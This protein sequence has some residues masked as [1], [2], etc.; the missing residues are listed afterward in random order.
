MKKDVIQALSGIFPKTV[1]S[2]ETLNHP[3]IIKHVSGIDVY[4]DTAKAFE[5]AWAKLG[6]DIHSEMPKEN[7][8]RPKVPGGTWEEDGKIYSDYGVYPT[9]MPIE[10]ES[11]TGEDVIQ[12]V[13]NYDT[14]EDDFDL[15]DVKKSLCLRNKRFNEAFGDSA[16]MYHVF[17]TT[18]FM[19]PVVKFGW[20][21]FMTAA[22][23]DPDRFDKELWEPW[24][25]ISRKYFQV[26]AAIDE[27]V[28]FC[29]DD[30]VMTTGPVFSP[31]FYDK[32]IF[33]KYEWIMEPVFEAGKKLV[34][35]CDGNMD[36]FLE[37]L[38][39]FPIAAI[40]FENPA[41]PFERVLDT[42]GEAGRGFIGGIS[43]KLLTDGS[44]EDVCK[45]VKEV[46]KKG[47]EYPGF[48]ISS[49]GG[50]PGNIPLENLLAYFRTRQDMG[51]GGSI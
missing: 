18:L 28:V 49:C 14:D 24:S 34:Y 43:T 7:A 5:V 46:C 32:Y 20:E 40:M 33:P 35:V 31:S 39:E 8:P 44:A 29:H 4:E 3:G 17:Y 2:K 13:F 1:P 47:G 41:T 11:L 51:C 25:K 21:P 23:L 19:W 16:V 30:L 48:I 37:R 9:S 15:E 36:I 26:L 50:L 22:A 45:H 42:W 12:T 10:D 38:L 27:E 6:I